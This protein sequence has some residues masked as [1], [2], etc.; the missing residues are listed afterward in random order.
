M[1][2]FVS[3]LITLL[4]ASGC[5]V[6]ASEPDGVPSEAISLSASENQNNP[7]SS[8]TSNPTT[9]KSPKAVALYDPSAEIEVEDQ[10]GDGSRL[11]IDE[12]EFSLERVWLVVR[13]KS[14]EL[15]H[16][17]LLSYGAKRA[18]I[19][20]QKPLVKGEYL[21]SLHSDNGDAE[22]NEALEPVIRGEERELVREDF[23]YRRTS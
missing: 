9:S 19:Q 16:A 4:V 14:G 3:I 2:A 15:F 18:S 21:V 23:E 17:E 5:S 10:S 13:S 1:K 7:S 8:P 12:I 22:F 11:K 20:L 6:N